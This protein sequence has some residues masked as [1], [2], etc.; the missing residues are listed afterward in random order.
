LVAATAT[1]QVNQ[2]AQHA[3]C[4]PTHC[5]VR[6]IAHIHAHPVYQVYQN[7][8]LGIGNGEPALSHYANASFYNL[9]AALPAAYR[10]HTSS[11][12]SIVDAAAAG[13][14]TSGQKTRFQTAHTS[15]AL[16]PPKAPVLML[17]TDLTAADM[18]LLSDGPLFHSMV[19]SPSHHTAAPTTAQL[20]SSLHLPQ[21]RPSVDHTSHIL[22]SIFSLFLPGSVS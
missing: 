21:H 3:T 11:R 8:S 20:S 6:S 17:S 4:S 9:H 5:I 1:C 15:A 7:S 10:S 19:T 12:F 2:F 16:P 18:L 22:R 13:V 14:S